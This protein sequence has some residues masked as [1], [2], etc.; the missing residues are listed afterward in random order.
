MKCSRIV[1]SPTLILGIE[2]LEDPVVSRRKEFRVTKIPGVNCPKRKFF[3]R[4]LAWR[5]V[6]QGALRADAKVERMVRGDISP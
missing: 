3:K 2:R 4:A 5:H 6:R 1:I